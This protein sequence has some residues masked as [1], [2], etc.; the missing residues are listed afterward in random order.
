MSFSKQKIRPQMI[1]LENEKKTFFITL[2][3]AFIYRFDTDNR[4]EKFY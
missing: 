4:K 3:R 1:H 2:I